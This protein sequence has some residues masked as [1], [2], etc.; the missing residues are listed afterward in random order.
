MDGC[1]GPGSCAVFSRLRVGADVVTTAVHGSANAV[2]VHKHVAHA[3]DEQETRPGPTHPRERFDSLENS[4]DLVA[5]SAPFQVVEF[6]LKSNVRISSTKK[7]NEGKCETYRK[8]GPT[9]KEHHPNDKD[10][11]KF[12]GVGAQGTPPNAR[13]NGCEASEIFSYLK[14]PRPKK[15]RNAQPQRKYD[16]QGACHY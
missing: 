10:T 14:C 3:S 2:L 7:E 6:M 9:D 16:S 1:C 15:D 13:Q 12:C 5:T 11:D 8:N 4:A